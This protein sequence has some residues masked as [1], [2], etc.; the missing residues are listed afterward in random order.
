MGERDP[1]LLDLRAWIKERLIDELSP[2]P[3]GMNR[4]EPTPIDVPYFASLTRGTSCRLCPTL[5]PTL[6]AVREALETARR[7][8]Q[9]G[10][11]GFAIF[12]MNLFQRFPLERAVWQQLARRE[13]LDAIQRGA[14]IRIH[15]LQLA[16]LGGLVVDKYSPRWAY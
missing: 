11:D 14:T 5:R 13:D 1:R 9:Q 2:G 10:A 12:D 8:Y 3:F 7:F 6:I 4:E 15:T 16:R